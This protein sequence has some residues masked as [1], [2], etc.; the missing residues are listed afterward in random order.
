MHEV[1]LGLG[2]GLGLGFEYGDGKFYTN[3]GE[4]LWSE[5]EVGGRHRSTIMLQKVFM[6][7]QI[8]IKERK[9]T[10]KP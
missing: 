7:Y 6:S 1:G 5:L 2:L 9:K 4:V 10:T 8:E 3:K